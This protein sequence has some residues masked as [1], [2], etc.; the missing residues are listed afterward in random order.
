MRA[1]SEQFSYRFVCVSASWLWG[2]CVCDRCVR[3]CLVA[4]SWC[5]DVVHLY[6]N[7][8]SKYITVTKLSSSLPHEQ[9]SHYKKHYK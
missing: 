3:L 6:K 8:T 2:V 9:M 5:S 1:T 4:T 7:K